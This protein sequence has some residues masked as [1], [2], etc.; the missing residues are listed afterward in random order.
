MTPEP[1]R[2]TDREEQL[3][4]L[5]AGYLERLEAGRAED[6]EA[7]LARHPEFA[8]ELAEFFGM[9]D[10]VDGVAVP[11]RQAV[12][13]GPPPNGMLWGDANGNGILSQRR[14]DAGGVA[15]EAGAA[16]KDTE[17]GQLG[18]FRLLHEVGRGGMGIVY[19]AEQVSLG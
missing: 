11:L 13:V 19:E 9:R 15:L 14:V 8:A 7:L 3:Q 1:S 2:P 17:R 10:Q 5:L 6:R 18:D 4:D 12:W 16:D